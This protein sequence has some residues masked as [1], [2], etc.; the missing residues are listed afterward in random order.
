MKAVL[1]MFKSDG[2]RREFPLKPGTHVIGRQKSCRIRVPLPSV[3]R[4]HAE[5][6][7]SDEGDVIVRDLGS[8]NG[9]FRNGSRVEESPLEP[10]D[11]LRIGPLDLIL[12]DGDE[13]AESP[14]PAAAAP[15]IAAAAS[16]ASDIEAEDVH[17]LG[18]LDSD[19]E[20]DAAPIELD[21]D[22]SVGSPSPLGGSSSALAVASTLASGADSAAD[23]GQNL[24]PSQ[25]GSLDDDDDDDDDLD[26]MLANFG[27]SDE[28][29]GSSEFDFLADIEVIEDDSK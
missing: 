26:D 19:F 29:A 12:A 27:K 23:S 2:K 20:D 8:S 1:V 10:G 28:S 11:E 9:T 15:A 17:D 25:L 5:L 7:V 13:A 6:V 22:D 21:L 16:V 24:P 3:S 4:R 14:A 18:E